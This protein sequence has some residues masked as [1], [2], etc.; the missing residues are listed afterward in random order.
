MKAILKELAWYANDTGGDIWPSVQTLADRTSLS[1]RGVQ[2]L[3]RE[4]ERRGAIQAIGSRL[5]GRRKTTHYRMD[6]GWLEANAQTA[7]RIRPFVRQDAGE[8][9][10]GEPPN[11]ERANGSAE[12]SEQSSPDHKE[13][14]YEQK[15]EPSSSKTERRPATSY[16][17]QRLQQQ[18]QKISSSKSIPSQLSKAQLEARRVQLRHQAEEVGR[19]LCERR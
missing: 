10:N 12:N 16:E 8:N 5:G 17:Y 3:L 19:K 6:L 13:H 4:L 18:A 2:K 14:E 7:N 15:K 11:S 1:R 9:R